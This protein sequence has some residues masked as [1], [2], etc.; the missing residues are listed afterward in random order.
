MCLGI[1]AFASVRAEIVSISGPAPLGGTSRTCISPFARMVWSNL[2]SHRWRNADADRADRLLREAYDA[3][4]EHVMSEPHVPA[5]PDVS[6][7]YLDAMRDALEVDD[8]A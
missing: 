7:T 8:D 4:R 1:P 5:P 6:R 3:A 2:D